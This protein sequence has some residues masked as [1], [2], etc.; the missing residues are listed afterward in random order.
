MSIRIRLQTALLFAVL[1]HALWAA[2]LT[3]QADPTK[4]NVAFEVGGTLHTVHGMFKVKSGMISFDP[5]S[6]NASG[7][8]VVDVPTGESGNG[9]R[10]HRMQKDILQSDRYPEAVFSPDHVSGSVPSQGEADV[11]IHGV[12]LFHGDKHEVTIPVK[13]AV[14]NGIITADGKFVM[15]YVE[16]GLKNPSTFVLRVDQK[17]SLDLHL[18]GNLR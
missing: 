7:Q 16:W 9:S 5:A 18:V 2:E 15:P 11:Q 1:A 8:V 13:V 12:L 6:G 10:D 4:S 3:I 14:Q 17:V